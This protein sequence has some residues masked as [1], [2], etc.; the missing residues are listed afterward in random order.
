MEFLALDLDITKKVGNR[1][2]EAESFLKLG[3]G[4]FKT[5]NFQ[6]AIQYFEQYRRICEELE[7]RAG[8]GSAYGKLGD[9][10]NSV[11]NFD[12]AGHFYG[13]QL[14]IATKVG[15]KKSE[16]RACAS[17][18]SQYH[19]RGKHVP[20]GRY[21]Q[22]QLKCAKE[23]G[24]KAG[25]GHAYGNLG[26]LFHS[27]GD[28]EKAMEYFEI[29][30]TIVK[31]LGDRAGEGTVCGNLG[32]V[33]HSLDNFE[34]AIEYHEMQLSI[35]NE[36]NSEIDKARAYYHKGCNL[37][38]LG[39]LKEALACYKSSAGLCNNIR[40][41]LRSRKENSF[42]DEWKI[43][44]FDEFHLVYMALCRTLL[45]LD[46]VVEA[47]W[48]VEQGRPRS[49]AHAI[50]S[51]YGS[52]TY[53]LKQEEKVSDVWQYISTNTVF[54]AAENNSIYFWLLTPDQGVR[55]EKL[56]LGAFSANEIVEAE[57]NSDRYLRFIRTLCDAAIGPMRNQLKGNELVIIPYGPLCLLPWNMVAFDRHE[58]LRIR[59]APSLTT[60]KLITDCRQDYH[61]A[62]GVLLVGSPLCCDVTPEGAIRTLR[63]IPFAKKE[64]EMIGKLTNTQPLTGKNA[65]KMAVLNRLR[66]SALVHI[67][68]HGS[69]TEGEIF[70]T[71]NPTPSSVVPKKKIT[72]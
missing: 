10:Y 9:T 62:S 25:K 63:E 33:Y 34:R 30:L 18:G 54:F 67:A 49:L 27:L 28:Y 35:A 46:F 22:R 14:E 64:V 39:S 23:S 5:A 40:A 58:S 16:G 72:C 24:D 17:L 71:P 48:A 69:S 43:N 38:S 19:G 7:D 11:G 52:L 44:L 20:A 66:N 32:R 68:T 57:W 1:K 31:E 42:T 8:E 50:Q 2:R 36:Q 51:R 6:E 45:K 41:S 26:E 47:L 55:F 61:R 59:V 53:Q 21:H 13:M 4:F 12:A 37:E 56:A 60:L 29:N 65:T 15:D 3:E 70:L